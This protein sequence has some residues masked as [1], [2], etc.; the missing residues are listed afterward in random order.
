MT[1][2]E[3]EI[4]A[5]ISAQFEQV[6]GIMEDLSAPVFARYFAADPAA[7]QLM[8]HMDHL[9]RGRMLNEV[10]RL[11]MS[12]DTASDG[13]YLDFEVRNHQWAYRVEPGMYRA[14]FVAVRDTVADVLGPAWQ[15]GMARDWDNRIGLLAAEIAA[16]SD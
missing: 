2:S 1:L 12:W 15:P 5:R 8:A 14:L 16:R 3:A 13:P 6:A 4:N 11:L 10:L 9:T 7:A